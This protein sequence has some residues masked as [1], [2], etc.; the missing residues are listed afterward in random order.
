VDAQLGRFFEH[1]VPV[2]RG[3]RSA[4]EAQRALGGSRSPDADLSFYRTLMQRNTTGILASLFPA[5]RAA[6]IALAPGHW[7][8]TAARYE[9]AHP[10]TSYEPNEFGRNFPIFLAAARAAGDPLLAALEEIAD[11]EWTLYALGAGVRVDGDPAL[12]AERYALRYY[13]FD[14]PRLVGEL[15]TDRPLTPPEAQPTCVLLYRDRESQQGRAVY[16]SRAAL[17]VLARRAGIATP[18]AAARPSEEIAEAERQLA[19]WRVLD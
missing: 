13:D 9:R 17:L 8:P 12:P 7:L 2:L 4:S 19:I 11:Y 10:A 18:A 14:A 15:R 6:F 5:T 3:E 1:W 16:P